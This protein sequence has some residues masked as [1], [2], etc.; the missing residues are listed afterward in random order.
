MW[1]YIRRLPAALPQSASLLS[2]SALLSPLTEVPGF[3]LQA[4]PDAEAFP[5]WRAAPLPGGGAAG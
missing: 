5:A 4:R 2:S 1:W 3:A